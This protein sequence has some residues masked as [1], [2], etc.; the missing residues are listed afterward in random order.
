MTLGTDL[1]AWDL[2]MQGFNGKSMYLHDKW[3]A[4]DTLKLYT[5]SASTKTLEHCL[6]SIGFLELGLE[7]WET[8]SLYI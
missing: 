7:T 6:V 3:I 1:S 5:D 2:F 8:F 4:A